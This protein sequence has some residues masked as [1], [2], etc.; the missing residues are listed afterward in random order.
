MAISINL[1]WGGS[2]G[3]APVRQGFLFA[4]VEGAKSVFDKLTDAVKA[5]EVRNNDRERFVSFEY[6][7]GDATVDVMSL[8]L[9]E[10]EDPFGEHVD[11]LTD[12][13]RR[14]GEQIRL[15]RGQD[16]PKAEA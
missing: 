2:F 1:Q 12:W 13:N 6:L 16:A 9:I 3:T 4:D 8:Q 10:L 14:M 5:Y 7:M 11:V 15:S